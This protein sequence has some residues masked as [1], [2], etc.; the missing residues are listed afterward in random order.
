M[1]ANETGIRTAITVSLRQHRQ[2]DQPPLPTSSRC[3]IHATW[4]NRFGPGVASA[5]R[6]AS[7]RPV[8]TIYGYSGTQ[9]ALHDLGSGFPVLLLHELAGHAGEWK[10]STPHPA[11]HYQVSRS[12]SGTTAT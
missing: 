3:C 5:S 4:P 9:L 1:L 6:V 7:M 11:R 10:R 8:R 12:I 2:A